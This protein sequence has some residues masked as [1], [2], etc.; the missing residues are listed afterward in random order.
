M[1]E[2]ESIRMQYVVFLNCKQSLSSNK[3]PGLAKINGFVYPLCIQLVYW[4]CIQ[5]MSG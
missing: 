3:M 4:N 5:L 2:I 1:D